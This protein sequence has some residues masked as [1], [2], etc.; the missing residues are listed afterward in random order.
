MSRRSRHDGRMVIV[1]HR[2][3]A[4]A[5]HALADHGS[6]GR[7]RENQEQRQY[8]AASPDGDGPPR[9]RRLRGC[10][11]FDQ[12]RPNASFH[13]RQGTPRTRTPR[14]KE[15][16]PS[17]ARRMDGGFVAEALHFVSPS[18]RRSSATNFQ[19]HP[20]RIVKLRPDRRARNVLDGRDFF[21]ATAFDLEQHE[22]RAQLRVSSW[23]KCA[24]G[25]LCLA[26]PRERGQGYL[27]RELLFPGPRLVAAGRDS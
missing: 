24:A 8:G 21:A 20:S 16:R 14:A 4:A 10:P 3:E 22:R 1:H 9:P 12:L 27:R 2:R 11:R 13:L 26:P 6:G 25:R 5:N 15:S 7:G 19:K 23:P 17:R 18:W